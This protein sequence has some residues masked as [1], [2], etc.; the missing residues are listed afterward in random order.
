MAG[1][2]VV[3]LMLLCSLVLAGV[4]ALAV[5]RLWARQVPA[6]GDAEDPAA[7]PKLTILKPL[8]GV[9][10]ELFENLCSVARQDYPDFEIVLGLE[11]PDD[12]AVAVAHRLRRE[13]PDVRIK[14]VTGAPA[15]A[16]N[17]KVNNLMHMVRFARHDLWLVSDSN[18]RVEPGYL[19]AMVAELADPAVGLVHSALVGLGDETL[20]ARLENLQMNTVTAYGVAGLE[21]LSGHPLVIGKSMLFRRSTLEEL[22]GFR[23]VANVLAEDYVLGRKFEAAGHRVRLSTHRVGVVNEGWSLSRFL[24]RQLRW[25]QMRRQQALLAY[26]IEPGMSTL[27]WAVALVP[28]ALA[29]DLTAPARWALLALAPLCLS[30]RIGVERAQLRYVR[31]EPLRLGELLPWALKDLLLL[32]LWGVGLFHRTIDWRGNR[33][34]IGPGSVLS[35]IAPSRRGGRGVARS[36]PTV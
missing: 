25:S 34:R 13:H 23:C 6:R 9:D 17:P 10:A 31:G 30:A 14:V 18:V 28:S 1:L 21:V 4:G 20:G 11:D 16:L 8:K 12:P 36:R 19:R 22:G 7:L 26:L 3:V 35:P 32:A 27:L 5:R 33:L 15:V 24:N 29:A 2:A